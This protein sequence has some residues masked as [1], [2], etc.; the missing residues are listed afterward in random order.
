[1]FINIH[2]K[3]Q[4]EHLG[5]EVKCWAIASF[6]SERFCNESH[7]RGF[8]DKLQKISIEAGM[9]IHG[10]PAVTRYAQGASDAEPLFR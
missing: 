2:Y 5:V 9:P 6:A 10:N 7:I 4:H 1:M 8:I 3:A